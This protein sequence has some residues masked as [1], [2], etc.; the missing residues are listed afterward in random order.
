MSPSHEGL[1]PRRERSCRRRAG[2]LPGRIGIGRSRCL[3]R[4]H[5]FGREGVS[6]LPSA[7]C[8]RECRRAPPCTLGGIHR[9]LQVQQNNPDLQGYSG[10]PLTDSNRRPPPYHGGALPTELRGREPTVAGRRPASVQAG[11]FVHEQV[12]AST[13]MSSSSPAAGASCGSCRHQ[14]AVELGAADGYQ[15]RGRAPRR[16]RRH[17]SGSGR[18]PRLRLEWRHRSARPRKELAADGLCGQRISTHDPKGAPR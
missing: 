9:C 1:G 14:V 8:T 15:H 18:S 7:A 2:F 17:R 11:C 3:T 6:R 12:D 16:R 5:L 4:R 13:G 10:S